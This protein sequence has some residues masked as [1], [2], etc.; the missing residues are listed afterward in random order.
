[1]YKLFSENL[2]MMLG[3][4]LKARPDILALA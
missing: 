3:L 1:M 4:G 2:S